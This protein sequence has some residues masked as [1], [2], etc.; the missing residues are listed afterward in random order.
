MMKIL[1][2]ECSKLLELLRV[3]RLNRSGGGPKHSVNQEQQGNQDSLDVVRVQ[4]GAPCDICLAVPPQTF[5][6]F[7][8]KLYKNAVDFPLQII[9]TCPSF[10]PNV[11]IFQR[12]IATTYQSETTNESS[13]DNGAKHHSEDSESDDSSSSN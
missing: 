13:C 6:H 9:I 8:T 4:G 12:A 3:C 7:Y 2:E 10:P 11:S 5:S 1:T